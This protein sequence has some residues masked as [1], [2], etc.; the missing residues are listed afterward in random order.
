MGIGPVE[1]VLAAAL[2]VR[3]AE[4]AAEKLFGVFGGLHPP[5][6]QNT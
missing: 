1:I 6:E 2:G 5:V 3:H 4:D